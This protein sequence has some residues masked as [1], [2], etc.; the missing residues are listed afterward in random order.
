MV[1]WKD[2][3]TTKSSASYRTSTY[4]RNGSTGCCPFGKER[5]GLQR[6]PIVLGA[7][8]LAKLSIP[9]GGP[10]TEDG[11]GYYGFDSMCHTFIGPLDE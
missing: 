9:P 1:H 7:S 2:L 4:V 11:K 8:K 5:G 10:L 3:V 6:E